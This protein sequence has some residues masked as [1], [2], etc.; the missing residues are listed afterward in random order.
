MENYLYPH[1]LP[2]SEKL[3]YNIDRLIVRV[4]NHKA[5]LIIADGGIGEGK[6]T[7][8]VHM[9]NYINNSKGLGRIDLIEGYQIAMGGADFLKKLRYCY[10]NKL[11]V[12]IYDE[13]GDFNRRGS[14]TQFNAMIN[15]T[16]DTFRAFKIIIILCLP[17]FSVLDNDLFEKNIPRLLLHCQ[18]RTENQGDFLA[19]SLYRMLYIKDKMKKL[20]VKQ[21]AYRIT[22][23]NFGGHFKDLPPEERKQLDKLSTKSKMN[24][25][26]KSEIK[27]EGL[28]T[29]SEMATKLMRSIVW[30]RLAVNNLKIR[31]ARMIKRQKYFSE[32]ALNLLSDHLEEVNAI[33]VDR[34]K[35][36]FK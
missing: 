19:Y 36:R 9:G 12:L 20:V 18:S 10:D 22:E 16:F 11:P 28:L 29:Y 24:I 5:S 33:R 31:P 17:S 34:L 4:D 27:V 7:L 13:A 35:R 25:L 2:F 30:V 26:R 23:C 15:R 3:A 1:G 21:T 6:T 32:D 14:L 8:S